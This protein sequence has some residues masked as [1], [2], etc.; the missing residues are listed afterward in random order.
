MYMYMFVHVHAGFHC[1]FG[2]TH[3]LMRVSAQSIPYI[4]CKMY[5]YMYNSVTCTHTCMAV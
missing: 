4:L 3:M 1:Y 5:M 2:T